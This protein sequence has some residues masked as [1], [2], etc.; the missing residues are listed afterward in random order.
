MSS[1]LD[2]DRWLDWKNSLSPISKEEGAPS[3]NGRG[4]FKEPPHMQ[5]YSPF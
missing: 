1:E 2:F 4:L 3:K 5:P